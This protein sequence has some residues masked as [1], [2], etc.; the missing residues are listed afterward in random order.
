MAGTYYRQGSHNVLCDR[1]GFK[2]KRSDCV[3]E[4][5]GLLVRSVSAEPRH[6][7]DYLRSFADDQSVRDPRS[8]SEDT[9]Q[10]ED[11]GITAADL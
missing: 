6:P 11:A 8:E 5:N 7:Q 3:R 1:T 9:F 2:V 10:A 4:W